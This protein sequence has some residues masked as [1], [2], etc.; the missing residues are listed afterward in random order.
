MANPNPQ[1]VP[2][3]FKGVR[4]IGYKQFYENQDPLA[5][6]IRFGKKVNYDQKMTND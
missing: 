6:F 4:D 1:H 3:R 5:E 2:N